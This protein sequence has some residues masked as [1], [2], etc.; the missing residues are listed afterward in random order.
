MYPCSPSFDV[1][2]IWDDAH[3]LVVVGFRY[4]QEAGIFEE[5]LR[6]PIPAQCETGKQA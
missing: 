5:P 3:I 6:D 2:L 1:C 4:T